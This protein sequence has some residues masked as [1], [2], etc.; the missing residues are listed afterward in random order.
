MIVDVFI[1]SYE[2][3][4]VLLRIENLK[5]VV[6]SHIAVQA[7]NTFRGKQRKVNLLN[8]PNVT[9]VV[10]TIPSGLDP[11]ESEKW[12]RDRALIEASQRTPIDTWYVMSDG[13]E[14]PHPEAILEAVDID[15]PMSLNTDY[16]SFYADWR[17]VDHVLAHQPTIAKLPDYRAMG[18]AN[19]ARWYNDWDTSAHR[20]WHLSSLGDNAAIKEKLSTFAHTEYDKPV[21]KA[22]LDAARGG[23]RDFLDRFD[24]EHTTDIPKSVPAHLLGGNR[25]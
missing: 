3:D 7:T 10:V 15:I 4:A 2:R 14:I 22:A 9:D 25:E 18:G 13:D 5:D 20:G 6:D 17:A 1:W 12:L 21:Y 24:L 8:L 19:D 16:R 23:M 11:W